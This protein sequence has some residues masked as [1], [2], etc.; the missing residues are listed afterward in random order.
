MNAVLQEITKTRQVHPVHGGDSIPLHSEIS[1]EEGMFIQSLVRTLDPQV[2]LEVGLA[3]GISALYICDAL[4]IREGTRHIA[5]DPNQHG[6]GCAFT[7][8]CGD[9]F[10]RAAADVASREHSGHGRF[11]PRRWPVQWP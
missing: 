5:I 6:G 7:H 2:V 11:Q 3:Y 4:R 9:P 10:R 8:R 1:D